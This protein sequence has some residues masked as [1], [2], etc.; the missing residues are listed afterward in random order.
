MY[1][2]AG[3]NPIK[4][5]DPDGRFEKPSW[6]LAPDKC[7]SYSYTMQAVDPYTGMQN[8][9]TTSRSVEHSRISFSGPFLG[10]EISFSGTKDVIKNNISGGFAGSEY[11][12][13]LIRLNVTYDGKNYDYYS[14]DVENTTRILLINFPPDKSH[15]TQLVEDLLNDS[16][17][18]YKGEFYRNNI[19]QGVSLN[20]VLNLVTAGFLEFISTPNALTDN[21]LNAAVDKLQDTLKIKHNTFGSEDIKKDIEYIL[22]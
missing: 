15:T 21:M 8:L 3:N 7:E 11:T 9:I 14:L 16:E 13:S 19:E 20:A 18:L 12:I 10:H 1:H 17:S 6:I 2:Y 5:T 22:P 4:Y